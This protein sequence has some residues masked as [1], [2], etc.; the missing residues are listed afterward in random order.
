MYNLDNHAALIGLTPPPLLAQCHALSTAGKAVVKSLTG[1][2]NIPEAVS[3]M[4]GYC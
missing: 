2:V 4:N 1:N 3:K